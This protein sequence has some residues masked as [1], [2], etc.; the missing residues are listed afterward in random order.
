MGK[1]LSMKLIRNE[2]I[3]TD[4]NIIYAFLFK[5]SKFKTTSGTIGS[6]RR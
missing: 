1:K 2:E 6:R 5:I 4:E 3:N